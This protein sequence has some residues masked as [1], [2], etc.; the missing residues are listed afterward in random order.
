MRF[1]HDFGD[2]IRA[3]LILTDSPPTKGGS[4]LIRCDWYGGEPTL[5]HQEQ[6]LRWTKRV[7]QT[8]VD[9]WGIKFA[10]VVQTGPHRWEFW[11]FQP[12]TKPS[13]QGV[14]ES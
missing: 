9:H 4:P 10:H 8:A 2:G 6:Y 14:I 7:Y 5:K 13:L 3:E 1:L 11:G 12:N